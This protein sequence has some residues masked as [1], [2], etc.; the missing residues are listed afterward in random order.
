MA[1]SLRRRQTNIDLSLSETPGD[2]FLS[3]KG[4]R[5]VKNSSVR[6]RAYRSAAI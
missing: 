2:G 5:T 6:V 1:S 3:K 4:P